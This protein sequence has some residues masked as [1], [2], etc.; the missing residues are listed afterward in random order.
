MA[1]RNSRPSKSAR[2]TA[3]ATFDLDTGEWG[4]GT[5]P[6]RFT[7][8]AAF[9]RDWDRIRSEDEESYRTAMLLAHFEQRV[10]DIEMVIYTLGRNGRMHTDDIV[11]SF[12]S[13]N[14]PGTL[15]SLDEVEALVQSVQ[16][17]W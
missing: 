2:T 10:G 9:V 3:S 17:P 7:M 6:R 1:S 14:H 11:A 5:G 13:I 12:R 15:L 16:E 4:A 8:A